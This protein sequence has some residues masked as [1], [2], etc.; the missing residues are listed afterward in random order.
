MLSAMT[1]R[2]IWQIIFAGFYLSTDKAFNQLRKI[3]P[4]YQTNRKNDNKTYLTNVYFW[5]KKRNS[6]QGQRHLS[7]WKFDRDH[8]SFGCRHVFHNRMSNILFWQVSAW[9]IS[10]ESQRCS[11]LSRGSFRK[12]SVV[13][14]TWT[15]ES[16]IWV[17][18]HRNFSCRLTNSCRF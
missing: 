12:A 4:F 8:G 14:Y 1:L 6:S 17:S 11:M 10:Q 18:K 2:D 13:L 3:F 9:I 15:E 7:E 16:E 5:S